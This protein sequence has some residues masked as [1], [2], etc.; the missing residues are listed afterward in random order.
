MIKKLCLL[1]L[2]IVLLTGCSKIILKNRVIEKPPF[3]L[4]PGSYSIRVEKIKYHE[5][6]F[7]KAKFWDEFYIFMTKILVSE[8]K[9]N[10]LISEEFYK[11]YP[12]I[13]KGE[14]S[15][16]ENIFQKVSSSLEIQEKDEIKKL[17][18]KDTKE[19]KKH[20]TQDYLN[21][22]VEILIKIL[23]D[24]E[25][26]FQNNKIYTELEKENIINKI[27]Q[28]RKLT[29]RIA[30]KAKVSF[31]VDVEEP[32]KEIFEKKKSYY[33]KDI[34]FYKK[35]SFSERIGNYQYPVWIKNIEESDIEKIYTGE[36]IL[37]N[38][39]VIIENKKRKGYIYSKGNYIFFVGGSE[40]KSTFPTYKIYIEKEEGS[41]NNVI[42]KNEKYNFSD[43]IG[44]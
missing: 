15:E 43:F 16:S 36:Y 11:D 22:Q 18:S 8:K 17:V 34:K 33:K 35:A 41:F 12:V 27:K 30:E 42:E 39:T 26:N 13:L 23:S 29:S 24:N 40:E 21:M 5:D 2:L 37:K 9:A 32:Y 1:F 6:V 25:E 4:E 10:I 19:N 20:T 14:L 7:E 3:K 28:K 38:K 31:I 44:G